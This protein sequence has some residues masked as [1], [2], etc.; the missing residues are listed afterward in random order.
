MTPAQA[1]E[2][3][4]AELALELP[5]ASQE[6]LLAYVD[7]LEKWNRIYNLTAIRDPL[8]MVTHHVLDSL[9]VVAH[10]PVQQ[11]ARIADVG[12]GGGLP[13]IPLAIA[14]PEWS[15]T[16]NDSLEKKAAFLRQAKIELQLPNAHVHEGRAERWT[17]A[18]PF[19]LVISRAFAELRDFIAVC[20]HLVAK[21]GWLAAMKGAAPQ[22]AP[23]CR[24]IPL[25]VPMLN[26]ERHLLLCRAP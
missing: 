24:V 20:A 3:G 16:L 18:A 25:R 7:L 10:L 11:A 2:G 22:D 5:A 15:I 8:E 12:S 21:D 14:R 26:A 13:G 4:L 9:A 6:K 1:L 17:P 19:E 23:S